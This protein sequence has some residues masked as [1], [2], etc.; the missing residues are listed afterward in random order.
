[1]DR[2]YYHEI[3]ERNLLPSIANFGFSGGFTFMHDNDPEHTSA[4]VKNWLVKQHKKMLLWLSSSPDLNPVEHLWNKLGRRLKKRQ[5][6]N[7]QELVNLLMEEW[8][9]TETS[10]LEKLAD[11]VP[12]RLYEC[13]RVKS[14]LTKY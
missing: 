5:S 8:N 2:L 14:Y 13:I 9:K 10:V 11:S 3:L 7:R 1:M 12:S 6:K 4:L